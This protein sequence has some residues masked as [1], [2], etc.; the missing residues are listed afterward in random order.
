[1]NHHC[2]FCGEE[3]D[4]P[5]AGFVQECPHC[6]LLLPDPAAVP[7]TTDDSADLDLLVDAATREAGAARGSTSK[8]PPDARESPTVQKS[9]SPRRSSIRWMRIVYLISAL[10]CLA[11]SAWFFY[12]S[13]FPESEIHTA[14]TRRVKLIQDL[15]GK[16]GGE[17]FFG[18][19]FVGA[20]GFCVL[21]AF[22]DE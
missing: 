8:E 17:V 12:A 15:F 6:K 18:L 19:I 16:S 1:M 11:V 20:A 2:P 7:G 21:K 10:V 22:W 3:V 9:P 5:E 13:T 14:T 4:P